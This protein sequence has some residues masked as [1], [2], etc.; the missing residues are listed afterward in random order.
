MELSEMYG[1]LLVASVIVSLVSCSSSIQE[2][3]DSSPIIRRNEISNSEKG[4]WLQAEPSDIDPFPQISD[5]VDRSDGFLLS[6]QLRNSR[7][8]FE[9]TPSYQTRKLE[10]GLLL[11]WMRVLSLPE[12]RSPDQV[13]PDFMIRVAN[14]DPVKIRAREDTSSVWFSIPGVTMAVGDPLTFEIFDR[15]SPT[16]E[17]FDS[18]QV[19]YNGAFPLAF[20]SIHTR[21]SCRAIERSKVEHKLAAE[22]D[23]AQQI[24]STIEK[25]LVPK[26]ASL[27]D[28]RP[29]SPLFE[30]LDQAVFNA[31]ALG[32]PTHPEVVSLGESRQA[33]LEGSQKRAQVAMTRLRKAATPF[34]SWVSASKTDLE[35][36]TKGLY[37]DQGATSGAARLYQEKFTKNLGFEN[38]SF[39]AVEIEV[40]ANKNSQKLTVGPRKIGN[41]VDLA[42]LTGDGGF[43]EL[44]LLDIRRNRKSVEPPEKGLQFDVDERPLSLLFFPRNAVSDEGWNKG[45]KAPLIIFRR[46][47]TDEWKMLFVHPSKT[48]QDEVVVP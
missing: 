14:Q 2:S 41:L 43:V 7:K 9:R 16:D 30:E 21:G 5:P 8:L 26:T 15:E 31:F 22:I 33:I 11:C 40:R 27:P 48:V 39:C 23:R 17:P 42:V 13:D 4:V 3:Q 36:R 10:R 25:S 28:I 47:G 12:D 37:C 34:E 18:V 1:K 29:P 19:S 35:V 24:L 20:S 6:A 45:W 46:A 44:W 32:G 38:H